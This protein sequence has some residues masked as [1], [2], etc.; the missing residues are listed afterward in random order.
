MR[1]L[2]GLAATALYNGLPSS[3][4]KEVMLSSGGLMVGKFWS[5]IPRFVTNFMDN[6]HFR[7][8]AQLRLALVAVPPGALC[9]IAK[10]NDLDDKCLAAMSDP[11]VHPHLCN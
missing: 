9:Q 6:D 8:S 10:A 1:C 2:N 4:E 5:E 7:M 11:C 3:F